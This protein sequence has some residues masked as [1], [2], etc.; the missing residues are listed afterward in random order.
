MIWPDENRN[1]G[2]VHVGRWNAENVSAEMRNFAAGNLHSARG[3]KEKDSAEKKNAVKEKDATGNVSRHI[4][5]NVNAET[6]KSM[7]VNA[8]IM[9]DVKENAEKKNLLRT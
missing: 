9:R 6:G 3:N 1:A 2:T 4:A 8:G 5:E 7:N